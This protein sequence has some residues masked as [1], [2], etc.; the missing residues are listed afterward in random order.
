MSGYKGEMTMH[1]MCD[2]CKAKFDANEGMLAFMDMCPSCRTSM[3]VELSDGV[4]AVSNKAGEPNC[5]YTMPI[6]TEEGNIRYEPIKIYKC[7]RK[8]LPKVVKPDIG[9]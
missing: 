8:S 5:Q 3:L 7:D 1:D 9:L 4:D 6:T 2:E